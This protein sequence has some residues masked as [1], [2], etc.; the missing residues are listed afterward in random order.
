MKFAA[1]LS[2]YHCLLFAYYILSVLD[3]ANKVIMMAIPTKRAKYTSP[4]RHGCRSSHAR[5]YCELSDEWWKNG[6]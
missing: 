6:E 2:C 4:N 1:L 3:L 5:L